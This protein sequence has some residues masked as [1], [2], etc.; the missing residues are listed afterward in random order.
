MPESFRRRFVFE[1]RG[2]G[3]GQGILRLRHPL[4][5]FGSEA[6]KRTFSGGIVGEVDEGIGVFFKVV[7]F[8]RGA[9]DKEIDAL[10]NGRG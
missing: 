6:A 7:Q 8:F 10:C 3:I 5:Q 4:H 1:K 9:M 2:V